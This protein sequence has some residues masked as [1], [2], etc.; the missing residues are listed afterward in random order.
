MISEF[1][2]GFVL[3][4]F[5]PGTESVLKS[6]DM[7]T[8][9]YPTQKYELAEPTETPPLSNPTR[10]HTKATRLPSRSRPLKELS[11]AQEGNKMVH[12]WEEPGDDRACPYG[13][14]TAGHPERADETRR[15]FVRAPKASLV[16]Y[17]V[18]S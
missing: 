12:D 10:S 15:T 17:R 13:P 14:S 6:C 8:V 3:H 9:S 16:R 2:L 1:P 4:S 18:P 7:E 11:L 5:G